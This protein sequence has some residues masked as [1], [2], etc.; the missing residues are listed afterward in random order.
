VHLPPPVLLAGR[1]K[2]GEHADSLRDVR[3]VLR[4]FYSFLWPDLGAQFE[5]EI[6]AKRRG[7]DASAK[8]ALSEGFRSVWRLASPLRAPTGAGNYPSSPPEEGNSTAFAAL[9]APEAP[10]WADFLVS[11]DQVDGDTAGSSGRNAG[12]VETAK[13]LRDLLGFRVQKP[14]AFGAEDLYITVFGAD[15]APNDLTNDAKAAGILPRRLFFPNARTQADV[16]LLRAAESTEGLL[17]LGRTPNPGEA[18]FEEVSLALARVGVSFVPFFSFPD[19][20]SLDAAADRLVSAG[21]ECVNTL[22]ADGDVAI[23][24]DPLG[25]EFALYHRTDEPAQVKPNTELAAGSDL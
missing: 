25:G 6:D 8:A 9:R 14:I 11:R 24:R 10:C 20:N 13:L 7:E 15:T 2:E 16:A 22:Q 1:S 4:R 21:G 12:E 18:S 23:M 5:F 19:K 3:A 17:L